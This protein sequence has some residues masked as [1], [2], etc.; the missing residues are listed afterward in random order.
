MYVD[1]EEFQL[2]GD[3]YTWSGSSKYEFNLVTY[4]ILEFIKKHDPNHFE[5]NNKT[6]TEFENGV[7]TKTSIPTQAYY[8]FNFRK[9]IYIWQINDDEYVNQISTNGSINLIRKHID[10]W[11][12]DN[13]P[14]RHKNIY[15][16]DEQGQF[17][18]QFNTIPT[19]TFDDVIIDEK[20]K[21]EIHDNTIFQ[22][23]NMKQNNGIIFH[24][25]PGT[26]KSATSKA[27]INAAITEG[28]SSCCIIS[29]IKF[30]TFGAF[31][32][33]Y[34]S[35]CVVIFEDVDSFAKD[36]ESSNNAEISDF[37]QL[38]S[39]ISDDDSQIIYI[40]TT[41]HLEKLDKAVA[42][43]PMRF[44]RKFEFKY[45]TNLEIDKLVD[46]YFK[47]FKLNNEQKALCYDL[48]FSGSHIKE[49]RRTAELM[50]LKNT[51]TIDSNFSDAVAKVKESFNAKPSG[52]LGF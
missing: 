25:E 27:I 16:Q 36:R 24:G 34:L 30:T 33:K 52:R 1:E 3:S 35:P 19:T 49:I 20:M 32:K 21:E 43:R 5:F 15:I 45:P 48:K 42:D 9:A 39:G 23:K 29:Y 7:G 38:I 51:T 41:N 50:S 11:I 4:C 46:L 2:T 8:A 40:A 18:V 17:K 10:K 26:G 14:L 22:L 6:H 47:D 13:N 28:F 12:T 31:L 44:N 37:L